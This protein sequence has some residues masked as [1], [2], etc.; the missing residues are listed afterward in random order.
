MKF[1]FNI[2]AKLGA[3]Q[4]RNTWLRLLA[5]LLFGLTGPGAS[6]QTPLA[7]TSLGPTGGSITALLADPTAAGRILYAGSDLN[8]VFVSRD[9]GGTWSTANSGLQTGRHVYAMAALGNFVYVAT[10]AGIYLSPAGGAI[11]WTRMQSPQAVEPAP[12][13]DITMMASAKARLY[14][15]ADC[16]STIYAST[17]AGKSAPN[18]NAMSLPLSPTGSVQTVTALGVL[19][20]AIA[21]GSVSSI[22]RLDANQT[23]IN[24]EA[25]TDSDGFALLSGL[26]G[27][28]VA[29]MVSSSAKWAF[30]CTMAG[31]VFQA[32]LS[33]GWPLTWTR[34][35][36]SSEE[37]S[38]CNG[39]TVA[40][41]GVAAESV[42]AMA[43]SR[44]AFA[45][46][47]FDDNAVTAPSFVPGPTFAM[48]NHVRAVLQADSVGR[49]S[50]LWAT[51]FGL[52]SSSVAD[53][54]QSTVLG[55]SR[56]TALNGPLTLQTPSQRL[57]NAQLQDA[58]Q[59]GASLFA[60]AQSDIGSYAD[61]MVSADHG[62]T[63]TRTNLAG[64]NSPIAAIRTLA[65]DA[66]H[67]VLYA[68]TDQGV[69]YLW[70]GT[71]SWLPLG[72][73]YDVTALA[74]GSRALYLGR[75]ADDAGSLELRAL[76][77]AASFEPVH[78]TPIANFNVRALVVSG[79]AVYAAGWVSAG[80]VYENAVYRASDFLPTIPAVLPS[81][82]AFGDGAF[83]NSSRVT[84]LAVAPGVVFV[85]GNG[86]LMQNENGA[87]GAV[88]GFT[89]L[90]QHEE[91]GVNALATDAV[92]LYVGTAQGLWAI[93]LADRAVKGLVTMNGS[94]DSALPSLFIN[95]LR[96][97]DGQLFVAT[98][99]GLATPTVTAAPTAPPGTG[100]GCSMSIAGEPDPVL[101]LLL[102]IAAVQI[103][104]AR[105][106]RVILAR[107]SRSDRCQ[108]QEERL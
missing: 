103:A 43:T 22:Y 84:S 26:Q 106:R 10:N 91:L 62:A 14:L 9:A 20:E 76:V 50:L 64:P 19:G 31:L 45:S 95:G 75:N 44:G 11:A 57:D 78:S 94:G 33:P 74:V 71:G 69:Y 108:P 56:P 49:S 61:V 38:T 15:A 24:S 90:P 13:C 40:K 87:W 83:S 32:D 12:A 46:T 105:R 63:W 47:V 55:I 98:S 104:Y 58:A 80:S 107:S 48:S 99:A 36:F 89:A 25:T 81:W 1:R 93:G 77:G 73:S 72:A 86:F 96:I 30:A 2:L 54:V 79:G 85:G 21:A 6:A 17:E 53:L 29:A 35:Q 23:W 8:G 101:W 66:S 16:E 88:N 3:L 97:L 82:R 70:Q 18:W 102:A 65:A 34:L 68:A 52:Y 27:E 5:V 51:E 92:N 28:H 39:L 42:L 4:C 41:V 59:L 67:N 37:P 60:I 7:W 100:G